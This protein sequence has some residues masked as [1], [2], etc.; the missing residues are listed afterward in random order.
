MKP[1][2]PFSIILQGPDGDGKSA[3]AASI[4]D[5]LPPDKKVYVI[6]L[7]FKEERA[8]AYT[9]YGDRIDV[10][11]YMDRWSPSLGK[12]GFRADAFDKVL[13]KID[14]L[15]DD[16]TYGAVIIDPGT[17]IKDI[18]SNA[19]LKVEGVG[20]PGELGEGGSLRFYGD[21]AKKQPELIDMLLGLTSAA[22]KYPKYVIIPWHMQPVKEEAPAK[23]GGQK[24]HSDKKHKG[25]TYEGGAV[26]V[27]DGSAKYY[28]GGRF[29][30]KVWAGKDKKYN[31]KTKANEPWYYLLLRSDGDREC[32][33]SIG[34]PKKDRVDNN[35][36]AMLEGIS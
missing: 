28:V 21:Q 5:L 26:P 33:I 29:D 11:V 25:I 9:R 4:V 2:K 3:A 27:M 12:E 16:T 34:L 8:W 32:K 30:V 20:R 23:G 18:S 6:A 22:A 17:R 15:Y 19:I 31:P 7:D 13:K 35:M 36:K 10:D 1:D 24:Q 14:S